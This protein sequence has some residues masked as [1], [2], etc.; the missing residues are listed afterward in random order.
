MKSQRI[1]FFLIALTS[2]LYSNNG[3]ATL[4]VSTGNLNFLITSDNL[5]STYYFNYIDSI[6]YYVRLRYFDGVDHYILPLTSTVNEL[7]V[8]GNI[9][10]I[11]QEF[12][13]VDKM[14]NDGVLATFITPKQTLTLSQILLDKSG[15]PDASLVLDTML[16][17]AEDLDGYESFLVKI[18]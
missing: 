13:K 16:S 2:L 12:Y 6:E 3:T 9:A 18:L 11:E 17:T 4:T 14:V 10:I 8:S 7:V 1:I 5:A 15:K